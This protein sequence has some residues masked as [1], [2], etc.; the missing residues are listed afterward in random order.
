[1]RRFR[2]LHLL[3][4]RCHINVYWD[5]CSRST[6]HLELIFALFPAT[7]YAC[8]TRNEALF[9]TTRASLTFLRKSGPGR[10]QATSL[11]VSVTV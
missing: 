1:M 9:P 11:G 6:P 4:R 5:R 7:G 2:R 10:A 8:Q 3:K